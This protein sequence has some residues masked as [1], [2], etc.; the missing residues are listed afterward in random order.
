MKVC[1]PLMGHLFVIP[2]SSQFMDERLI[3]YIKH[4]Q[5]SDDPF[6][7]KLMPIGNIEQL[8]FRFNYM[9]G[10]QYLYLNQI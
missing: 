10:K 7:S 4:L 9:N 5:I 2:T 3:Q 6:G 8:D 1:Y